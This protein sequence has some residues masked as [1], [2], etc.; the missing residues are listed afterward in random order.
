VTLKRDREIVY[1]DADSRRVNSTW[2]MPRAPER[3]AY[4][5]TGLCNDSGERRNNLEIRIRIL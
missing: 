2:Q 1:V 5:A 4:S 3:V